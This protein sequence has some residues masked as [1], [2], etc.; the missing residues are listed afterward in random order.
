[1]AETATEESTRAASVEAE[2]ADVTTA[3]DASTAENQSPNNAGKYIYAGVSLPGIKA[4]T[5]ITG[6]IPEVLNV[7]FV[8]D[9]V[10]PVEEYTNFLKKKAV[11]NS[12]EAFCY[13]KSAEY[14]K[15]L[16]K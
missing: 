12:R 3:A 15:T 16:K 1:V 10:I 13:R 7:P 5:V 14:A 6:A 11:T 9:L 8:K 4:N 2:T